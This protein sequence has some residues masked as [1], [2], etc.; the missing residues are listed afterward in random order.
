MDS[1]Y[2]CNENFL[3]HLCKFH[4]DH[5]T[6][7][8]L[9]THRYQCTIYHQQRVDSQMDKHID[10]NH[11][12]FRILPHINCMIYELRIRRCLH[13]CDCFRSSGNRFRMHND[14]NLQKTIFN[15]KF[16]FYEKITN[17]FYPNSWYNVVNINQVFQYI[18]LY[19]HTFYHHHQFAS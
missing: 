5:C 1:F 4:F 16:F 18:H 10:T 3:W 8:A 2:K 7:F 15:L 12:C 9:Y 19:H 14:T 11:V 6:H 13:M 17:C